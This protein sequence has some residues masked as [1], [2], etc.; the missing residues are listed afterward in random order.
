MVMVMQ[1][2]ATGGYVAD[3]SRRVGRFTFPVEWVRQYRSEVLRVMG[4]CAVVRAEQRFELDAIEYTAISDH[5]EHVD[6]QFVVPNYVW[7]F[8][9]N[10]HFWCERREF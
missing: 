5:F 2:F 4:K 9:A 7:C 1:K 3:L 6:R 8:D 10:G